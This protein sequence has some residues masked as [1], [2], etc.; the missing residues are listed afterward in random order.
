MS[1]APTGP[2]G[3]RDEDKL[4]IL[5]E[6]LATVVRITKELPVEADPYASVDIPDPI[7]P[8]IDVSNHPAI[9]KA[10]ASLNAAKIEIGLAHSAINAAKWI[11]GQY[12]LIIGA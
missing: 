3:L 7:D 9:H 11:G 12:G 2:A 8:T 6:A 4:A 5:A 1:D 10:D